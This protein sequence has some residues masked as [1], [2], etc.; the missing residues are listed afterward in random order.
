MVEESRDEETAIQ[1]YHQLGTLHH[2]QYEF[3]EAKELYQQALHL[4]DRMGNK[5]QMITEFYHLGLLEQSRGILYDEAEE[6]Y[7]I[8]LEHLEDLGDQRGVG[9]ESRQL[10][11]LFHE[12]QKYEEALE[13]YTQARDIFEQMGDIQRLARTYG[14]I[15]MVYEEQEDVESALEWVSRTYR[16][17]VEHELPVIIQVKAHLARL[18]DKIGNEEFHKWWLTHNDEVAPADLDVDTSAIF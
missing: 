6:W 18:R 3:D 9:D 7:L 1:I 5:E 14:Q 15:G 10:G 8:A 17:M 13:W 4:S 16:L 2:A 12:Q 11:V